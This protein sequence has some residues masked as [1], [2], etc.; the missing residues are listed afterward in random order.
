MRDVLK[1]G[2]VFSSICWE[3]SCPRGAHLSCDVKSSL[4]WFVMICWGINYCGRQTI[5]IDIW[6]HL[7]WPCA[8]TNTWGCWFFHYHY[9]RSGEGTALIINWS[10]RYFCL[11][12]SCKFCFFWY[13]CSITFMTSNCLAH[14]D[15]L[16]KL[17]SI[18][19]DL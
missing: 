16:I 7:Q 4:V 14:Y 11:L 17:Q 19:I 12:T 10:W 1:A 5:M 6:S 8:N 2:E 3:R 13:C 9:H 18:C 15:S